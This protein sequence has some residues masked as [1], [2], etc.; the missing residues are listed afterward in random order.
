MPQWSPEQEARFRRW[1]AQM[2]QTW[3]LDPDPDD[4][5]QQYDYRAAFTA[6]ARPDKTGHWP[7]DFKLGG[8]PN[9]IVGGFHVQTG[10]RVPGTER[11]DE[12]TLIDLGWDPETAKRLAGTPEPALPSRRTVSPMGNRFRDWLTR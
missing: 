11:A 12:A 6:G 1:Y 9:L 7:S 4:P 5:A 8:H 3:A 10:E 2:A